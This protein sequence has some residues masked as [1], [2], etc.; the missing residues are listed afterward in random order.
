MYE[1]LA[2]IVGI[3]LGWFL[4]GKFGATAAA[5]LAKAQTAASDV[6]AAVKKL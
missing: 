3:A 1:V 2:L 4:K 5:D 6:T